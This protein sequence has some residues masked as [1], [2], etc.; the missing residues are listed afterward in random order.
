[1]NS[2]STGIAVC[3]LCGWKFSSQRMQCPQCKTWRSVGAPAQAAKGIVRL[4]DVK[5]S[6]NEKRLATGPWDKAF[7][8]WVDPKGNDL[9]FGLVLTSVN[10]F[11]GA[12][13]A[14]KT[15]LSL[16][17]TDAIAKALAQAAT[18]LNQPAPDALYIGTEQSAGEIKQSGRRLRLSRFE[19]ILIIPMGTDFTMAMIESVKPAAVIL[20]SLSGLTTNVDEQVNVCE[21]FKQFSTK[22]RAP[23]IIIDHVTKGDDYAGL[24]KL[25]HVVDACFTIYPVEVGRGNCPWCDDPTCLGCER[26]MV[27]DKNRFGKAQTSIRLIMTKTGLVA[28]P[29][30]E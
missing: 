24:M 15:T 3:A 1:M 9:E 10:L 20:D 28:K 16:Q 21:A 7:G 2:S 18:L 26:E 8:A 19:N 25:Q 27:V 17:V 13:G 5:E 6:D 22:T 29:S 11:A 4:S 23:V 30:E 12:P 14:G